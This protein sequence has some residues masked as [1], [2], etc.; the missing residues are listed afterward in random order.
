MRKLILVISLFLSVLCSAQ[1]SIPDMTLK[2]DFEAQVKSIDEFIARFNGAESK[3][4][5]A[6]N[7]RNRENNIVSLFDFEMSKAGFTESEFKDYINAFVEK[8]VSWEGHLNIDKDVLAE[9]SCTVA[10]NGKSHPLTLWLARDSTSKGNRKWGIV[11]VSGLK[12]AGVYTDK[13]VTISPVEHEVHF[14][15][16]PDLVNHN[17]SL[18]PDLRANDKDIDELSLF[19]GL[20]MGKSL[21]LSTI[22]EE[23][24]YFY[25]V[26]GYIF[27]VEEKGRRGNNSGW[28]ITRLLPKSE[29]DKKSYISG[30][31]RN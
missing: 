7:E 5:I 24:F 10:L 11:S 1:K 21:T 12:A 9:L 30:L 19:F 14:M 13:R 31:F 20:C 28:L 18:T 15:S 6:M 23:K 17:R 3:K 16:L 27:V 29:E 22:N 25:G 4:G 2:A 26:P 8:A